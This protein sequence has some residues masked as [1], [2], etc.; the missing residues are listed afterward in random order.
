MQFIEGNY[1]LIDFGHGRK[2]EKVGGLVL[3]RPCPGAKNE[4]SGSPLWGEE[5]LF[6]DPQ[7]GLWKVAE[8]SKPL[9]NHWSITTRSV[10]LKLR[11]TAAGQIGI[12]PEHWLHWDWM[13]QRLQQNEDELSSS[14]VLSLFAYTGATTLFLASQGVQVTHVDASKPTV[15]WARENCQRST[16]EA[17]PIRWL[18]EDAVRYVEREW[19][20][21]NQYE[22]I[23]LDPPT[24]GHGTRDEAWDIHKD[25]VILL[26]KCWEL[27]SERR[28]FVLLCGHSPGV[29]LRQ[30]AR[31]LGS[32]VGQAQLGKNTVMQAGLN[33]SYGRTLDCGF[34]SRF[35]F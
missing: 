30:V 35:E 12:F 20:R 18:V 6:F 27:L 28:K 15:T 16:L 3:S 10:T 29:D 13:T 8:S 24:Y 21:G 23:I 1:E 2:L 22:A 25:L 31:E 11:P 32:G 14:R 19:K 9:L 5:D 4:P 34:V 7:N 17:A 26:Q 33:D